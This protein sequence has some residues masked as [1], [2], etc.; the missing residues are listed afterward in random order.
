[1]Q[2]VRFFL[3]P[4]KNVARAV[5]MLVPLTSTEALAQHYTSLAGEQVA[6]P[7]AEKA[8]QKK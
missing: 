5:V 6:A 7:A 4:D 1:M 3:Y 2:A 8:P